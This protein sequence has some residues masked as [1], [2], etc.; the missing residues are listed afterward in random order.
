M[1]V[2]EL[3]ASLMKKLWCPAAIASFAMI[4]QLGL[5][6]AA[7]SQ[8]AAGATSMELL[9]IMTWWWTTTNRQ[10]QQN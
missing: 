4:E 8:E 3:M 6:V 10:K 9:C 1:Y 5:S 7:N 2:C